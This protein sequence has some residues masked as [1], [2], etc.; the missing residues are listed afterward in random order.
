MK[1]YLYALGTLFVASCGNNTPSESLPDGPRQTQAELTLLEGRSVPCNDAGEHIFDGSRVSLMTMDAIATCL[2]DEQ[3]FSTRP[4]P[5]GNDTPSFTFSNMFEMQWNHSMDMISRASYHDAQEVFGEQTSLIGSWRSNR[6]TQ[7]AAFAN[8]VGVGESAVRVSEP[9]LA[10]VSPSQYYLPEK[11]GFENLAAPVSLCVAQRL[12]AVAPGAAGAEGVLLSDQEQRELLSAVRDHAQAAML[13]YALLGAAF[14]NP[15]E[16]GLEGVSL[17]Q[18]EE[19]GSYN[20]TVVPFLQLWG[21]GDELEPGDQAELQEI[22]TQMGE[23]FA[24]AAQ[25]HVTVAE[26]LASLFARSRS[27]RTPVHSSRPS[28]DTQAEDTWGAG[29]WEQRLMALMFGGEPLANSPDG[30]FQPSAARSFAVGDREGF[31]EPMDPSPTACRMPMT[32]G[33]DDATFRSW[34][35]RLMNRRCGNSLVSPSGSTC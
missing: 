3:A 35:S 18:L 26:E 9:V 25:L 17:T 12:R 4:N 20:G 13:Q 22:V 5:H 21:R 7:G 19:N 8:C 27:S 23:D 28:F 10:D 29:S 34:K 14:S 24:T 2:G 11:A 33:F 31:V 32:R 30:A 1:T 6:T 15:L 16:P